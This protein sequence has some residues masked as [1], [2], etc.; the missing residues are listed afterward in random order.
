MVDDADI[1]IV[2][3]GPCGL[4][5]AISAQSAGFSPLVLD[6]EVVV[7]TIAAYPTYVRFSRRT[8]E[9]IA[10]ATAF[11]RMSSPTDAACIAPTLEVW[12]EVSAM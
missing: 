9:R 10:R 5:A 1:V 11:H 6:A 2:G 12:S 7:S 3:A 8:F 4:A